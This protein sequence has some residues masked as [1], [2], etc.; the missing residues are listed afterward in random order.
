M[1]IYTVM[2]KLEHSNLEIKSIKIDCFSMMKIEIKTETI[3]IDIMNNK[4]ERLELMDSFRLTL[5]TDGDSIFLFRG[6]IK[7]WRVCSDEE[8]N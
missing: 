5:K 1:K 8:L 4:T 7:Y 3:I 2:K 6:E